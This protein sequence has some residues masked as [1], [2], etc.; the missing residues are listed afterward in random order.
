MVPGEKGSWSWY[1]CSAELEGMLPR[2]GLSLC[3][4]NAK[5]LL[6]TR[7]G[8]AHPAKGISGGVWATGAG[9]C[10]VL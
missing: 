10:S 8:S 7:S 6:Q 9:D 3:I 4:R 5:P 2:L 1:G